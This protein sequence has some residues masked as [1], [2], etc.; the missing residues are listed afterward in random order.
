MFRESHTCQNVTKIKGETSY[1]HVLIS[2]AA[3]FAISAIISGKINRKI[4]NEGQIASCKDMS[5]VGTPAGSTSAS[6]RPFPN[7]VEIFSPRR[8][9]RDS[10]FLAV[11]D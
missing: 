4:C 5:F 3:L 10:Y 6:Y 2:V 1:I 7:W 11:I 9:E 8:G